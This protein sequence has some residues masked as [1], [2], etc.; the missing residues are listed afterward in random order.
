[1]ELRVY[2]RRGAWRQVIKKLKQP[3]LLR[4]SSE[5]STKTSANGDT[6][7]LALPECGPHQWSCCHLYYKLTWN[8]SPP[9]C[10]A[11]IPLSVRSSWQPTLI[12]HSL[13]PHNVLGVEKTKRRLS[14]SRLDFTH[15]LSCSHSHTPTP[16]RIVTLR[17]PAEKAKST[18]VPPASLP[19]TPIPP[20][21][22]LTWREVSTMTWRKGSSYKHVWKR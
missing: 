9:S 6:E 15:T 5:P 11:N 7:Q 13:E 2:G 21:N 16:R 1:M 20:R 10:G 3:S 18:A 8:L 22:S 4:T 14:Q 12:T 19:L 17:P